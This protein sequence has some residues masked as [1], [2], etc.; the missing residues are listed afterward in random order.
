MGGAL[1]LATNGSLYGLK[2]LESMA[3][4]AV[5]CFVLISGYFLC[6]TEKFQ[7]K[8]IFFIYILNTTYLCVCYL[9]DVLIFKTDFSVK[10]LLMKVIPTNYYLNFYAILVFIAPLLNYFFKQKKRTQIVYLSVFIMLFVI[11]PTAVDLFNAIKDKEFVFPWMSTNGDNAGYTL[12]YFILMYLIGGF[13]RINGVKLKKIISLP[14]YFGLT[15]VITLISIKNEVVWNYNDAFVT[16]SAIALFLFFERINKPS[17]V[18][19][20]AISSCSLGV[21]VLHTTEFVI[22]HLLSL[23]DIKLFVGDNIISSMLYVTVSAIII[24]LACAIADFLLRLFASPIKKQ[25][26][27][28]NILNKNVIELDEGDA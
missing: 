7:I 13:I 22:P 24:S 2:A 17:N 19:V 20:S 3:V 14:L 15:A 25:M 26:L 10:A 5:P 12:L 16:F 18:V 1:N 21:F 11:F 4:V 8:K 23:V 9:L 27:R 28:I 6:K